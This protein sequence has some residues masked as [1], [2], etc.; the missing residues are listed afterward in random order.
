MFERKWNNSTGVIENTDFVPLPPD[1]SRSTRAP[2]NGATG[3]SPSSVVLKW[4]GG[5]WAHKYDVL[6]GT[7]PNNLQPRRARHRSSARA[8]PRPTYQSFTAT[9]PAARARPTTG[10][11]SSRTMANL[12]KNGDIWSFTTS[13]TAPPPPSTGTTG[14]RRHRSLCARRPDHRDEMVDRVG[15]DRGRRQAALEHERQRGQGHDRGQQPRPA[16][17]SS[18]SAPSPGKPYHLWMRGHAE[19]NVYTNDSVFVQFSN[20][21]TST[22]QPD[23]AHRDDV[24]GRIQPRGLQR[25]RRVR[26]GMAGQRLG[27]GVMGAKIYFNTTGPQTLRIQAPRRRALDRSDHPLAVIHES[28]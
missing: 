14:D 11:S 16:T 12:S 1:T 4:Y 27:P 3:L 6:L 24:G 2:A 5:P 13:G 20:S 8:N 19:G 26:L 21:V 10:A 15:R 25:L 9:Q 23:H 22:G 17:S 28:S 7:D 18:P